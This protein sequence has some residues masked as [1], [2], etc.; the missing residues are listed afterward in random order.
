M[1]RSRST[2]KAGAVAVLLVV[3]G[4]ARPAAAHSVGAECT[5]RDGVVQVEAY[6]DDDTSAADARV[7]VRNTAGDIVAEGRTD[8]KGLWHFSVPSP[9]LYRVTVDAGAGHQT[10]IRLHIPPPAEQPGIPPSVAEHIHAGPSRGEFTRFPWG[11]VILGLAAISFL[12]L[13]W[14]GL[15]GWRRRDS[16]LPGAVQAKLPMSDL[17]PGAGRELR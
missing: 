4:I 12:F 9:G 14:R 6:F 3:L 17:S 7:V 5:L 15:H 2:Q 16:S 13:A 11:G 10:T 1:P 8:A